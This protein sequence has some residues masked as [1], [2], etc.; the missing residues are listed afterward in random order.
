MQFALVPLNVW[1]IAETTLPVAR[2]SFLAC[3]FILIVVI[4]SQDATREE[5]L[6]L[7]LGLGCYGAVGGSI[8]NF[9]ASRLHL[10][11]VLPRGRHE[12]TIGVDCLRRLEL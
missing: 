5:D 3:H 9:D 11:H 6:V 1:E 10:E 4:A 12:G 8:A 2:A 7:R